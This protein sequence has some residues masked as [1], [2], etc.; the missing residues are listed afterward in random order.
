MH[1]NFLTATVLRCL[2][3]IFTWGSVSAIWPATASAET[4]EQ[5]AQRAWEDAFRRCQANQPECRTD[6]DCT[7]G[8][9]CDRGRCV[10][11]PDPVTCIPNC[12]E[13]RSDGTCRSYGRDFCGRNP[14]CVERCVERR[15]DGSC[16]TW[17]AD[18]CGEQAITCVLNCRERRSDGTCRTYGSDHCGPWAECS[19]NCTERR[20]DGTCRTWGADVCN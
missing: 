13:R 3:V 17:G 10:L 19:P 1:I 6:Q 7:F 18:L 16:R 14:T 8:N 5:V 9:R 12:T 15:S 11:A 4:C 20:S 2:F